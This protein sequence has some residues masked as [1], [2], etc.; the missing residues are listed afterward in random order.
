[1]FDFPSA[2]TV[3]QV[4]DKY[5]WDGEKW[6]TGA[7][8][9]VNVYAPQKNYI[10]NGGMQIAQ[11]SGG[12]ASSA[13][14]FWPVDMFSMNFNATSGVYSCSRVSSPTPGGSPARIRT[15]VTTPDAAVAAT[16]LV[17][18]STQVEG[19]RLIDLL[20][21]TALAKTFT[22][23]FGVKAPA[24]TYGV[25]FC[26]NATNR[27]YVAEYVIAPG[28]ANTDVVK[29]ITVPGDVTG[30]WL[31]DTQ[32]GIHIRWGL[33]CGSTYAG[34]P[35]VWGTANLIS[36]ANQYNFMGTNGNVFELFDVAMYQGT[37]APAYV[38]PDYVTELKLCERYI[39]MLDVAIVGST[40][41]ATG[42]AHFATLI[43]RTEMRASPTITVQV[44]LALSVATYTAGGTGQSNRSTR[45]DV[46]ATAA[47]QYLV[48]SGTLKLS[49]KLL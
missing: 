46:V 31:T 1:M 30:T 26:N 47:G 13:T 32:A 35:N 3:G 40:G 17:W 16:D 2:P 11:E 23:R 29:T 5:T 44:A 42:N 22:L 34:A 4:Y 37:V 38:L 7:P 19:S 8:N 21:G 25:S 28:E 18:I 39:Q 14:Y 27:V 12:A 45:I 15:T 20:L 48:Y 10:I 24:G 33:M 43:H 6:I 9:N 41:T 36:S 49:A